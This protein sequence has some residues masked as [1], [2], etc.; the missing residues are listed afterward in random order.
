ML[1]WELGSGSGV[2]SVGARAAEVLHGLLAEGGLHHRGTM[3]SAMPRTVCD[4]R[5]VGEC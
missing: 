4:T 5:V 3:L 1:D 2:E